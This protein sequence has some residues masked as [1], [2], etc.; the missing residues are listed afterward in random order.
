MRVRCS[1]LAFIK[2]DSSMTLRIKWP[3]DSLMSIVYK[4]A[5][6]LA[7]KLHSASS[8]ILAVHDRL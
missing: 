3:T 2:R 4:E 5:W 1:S 7:W 8:V 6:L